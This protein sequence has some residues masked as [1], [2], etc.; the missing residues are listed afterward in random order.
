[1]QEENGAALAYEKFQKKLQQKRE[2]KKCQSNYVF[3]AFG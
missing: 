1:M 3:N 2:N